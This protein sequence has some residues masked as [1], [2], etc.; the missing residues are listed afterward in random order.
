MAKII[1]K[2]VVIRNA[3]IKFPNFAG[4]QEGRFNLKGQR[5]FQ[6]VIDDADLAK[7]LADDGWNVRVW[8]PDEGDPEYSIKVNVKYHHDGDGGNHADPRIYQTT[9]N[10]K[11]VLLPE[12]LVGSLDHAEIESVDV[13]FG[14]YNWTNAEGKSGVSAY[15]KSVVVHIADDPFADEYDDIADDSDGTE[16]PF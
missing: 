12:D 14:P 15:A 4:R 9:G 3:R 10:R 8:A 11:R 1:R 16:V 13:Q 6:V 5:N 7:K 2:D